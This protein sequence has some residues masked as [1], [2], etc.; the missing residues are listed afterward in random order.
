MYL[1]K[2]FPSWTIN[3]L[4]TTGNRVISVFKSDHIRKPIPET[5]EPNYLGLLPILS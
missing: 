3:V 1:Y 5:T 2:Q 4:F